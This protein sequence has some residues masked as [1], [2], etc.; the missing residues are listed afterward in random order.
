MTDNE[1]GTGPLQAH[2]KEELTHGASNQDF[3]PNRYFLRSL[4]GISRLRI[5][6]FGSNSHSFG[7]NE[8]YKFDTMAMI[9]RKEIRIQTILENPF[10]STAGGTMKSGTLIGGS[11]LPGIP[12][13]DRPQNARGPVW[14]YS[15]N[16]VIPKNINPTSNSVF[17]SAVVQ[18]NGGFAGVFRCDDTARNMQI[19][20]GT[21][22]DGLSWEIEPEPIS[23][24]AE[25]PEMLVSEYKYDP[26]VT[27][28][29]DRFYVTWCN[30]YHGPT[31]GLGWSEDFKTFH[32]LENAF[33]PFNR[34][35]V[36]FPRKINGLYVLLSRPSDSGHTPFGEI[37]LSQ[38]RDLEFW[39]RHRWVMSPIKEENGWQSTKIGA[40]PVP[41]E[42]SEGWLLIYHGVNTTC[43]GFIYS[44][45]A[46]LLDLEQPWKVI[47]RTDPYILTPETPYESVG[48]VPNV[49]FPCATLVDG[50]TGRLAL[51]YGCADTVVGLAFGTVQEIVEL[52]KTHSV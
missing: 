16:P 22:R 23:F 2:F 37:Y 3:R 7:L 12:W 27:W 10:M 46:A 31:I 4:G 39:G 50:A 20:S 13:E 47:A 19:H 11:P 25:D 38:S 34:N 15:R 1:T 5:L 17:N 33:L 24:A 14:R 28:I 49:C 6:L 29:D 30:G 48:N 44:A 45:G 36:L 43:N 9:D 52:T 35:G 41:I 18:Y 8:I 40:G 32:Q 42:T 51:Y 26:R 21:S